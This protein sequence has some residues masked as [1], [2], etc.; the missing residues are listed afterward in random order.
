MVSSKSAKSFASSKKP[1]SLKS[2]QEE[3][4][5]YSE[6]T[7]DED[8][9]YYSYYSDEE[10]L[11]SRTY[12]SRLSECSPVTTGRSGRTEK[13]DRKKKREDNEP[14]MFTKGIDWIEKIAYED[15]IKTYECTPAKLCKLAEE[16][17]DPKA[18]KV[19]QRRQKA[20]NRKKKKKKKKKTT[21]ANH[22]PLLSTIRSNMNNPDPGEGDQYQSVRGEV[23]DIATLKTSASGNLKANNKAPPEPLA[24]ASTP[25]NSQLKM[26]R[27]RV[28]KGPNKYSILKRHHTAE[29]VM[30]ASQKSQQNQRVSFVPSMF[31]LRKQEFQQ[32][33]QPMVAYA[34]PN[35]PYAPPNVSLARSALSMP[36]VS[37]SPPP[38]VTSSVP[39]KEG[40][41][42]GTVI[43]TPYG[44][45]PE[46]IQTDYGRRFA[47]QQPPPTPTTDLSKLRGEMPNIVPKASKAVQRA[48]TMSGYSTPEI[49]KKSRYAPALKQEDALKSW[50]APAQKQEDA[51]IDR[52]DVASK[53]VQRANKMSGYSTPEIEKKSRYAPALKQ[54]DA[55]KSWYAP[56]QPPQHPPTQQQHHPHAAPYQQYPGHMQQQ[57]HAPQHHPLQQQQ[58]YPMYP[59]HP[60]QYSM[61]PSGDGDF[62]FI[63]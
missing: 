18:K 13:I 45:V 60:Q 16:Q 3:E 21:T 49:E 26:A 10:S 61:H 32:Q 29:S 44:R 38:V 4:S 40:G 63:C 58:Q 59:H 41:A 20:E 62:I 47:P 42:L 7:D 17:N 30:S 25:V 24:A 23:Y 36:A 51:L 56:A 1:S 57:Y 37:P 39:L 52:Y 12:D 6:Y 35:V 55:L 19:K 50:Y 53:A 43:K 22:D 5:I 28:A 34:P 54:E 46:P 14:G 33:A 15:L 11:Y 31:H 48:N 8:L 27:T 2:V 9:S